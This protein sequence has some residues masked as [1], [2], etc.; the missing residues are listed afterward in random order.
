M[1]KTV[2]MLGFLIALTL[3]NCAVLDPIGLSNRVK[4]ADARQQIK[5]ATTQTE[6]LIFG[7]LGAPAALVAQA[8][9]MDTILTGAVAKVDD[10]KYYKKD[11][12]DGCVKEIKTTGLLVLGPFYTVLLTSK[13][14]LKADGAV[15]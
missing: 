5:D 15:I 10:S 3:G 7:S 9:V 11:D 2:Y 1:K 13:C 6:A 12:V 8:V 4:G 14:D